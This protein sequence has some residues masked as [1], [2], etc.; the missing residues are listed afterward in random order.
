MYLNFKLMHKSKILLLTILIIIQP[1]E[2]QLIRCLICSYSKDKEG[3]QDICVETET[4]ELPNVPSFSTQREDVPS[5]VRNDSEKFEEFPHAEDDRR[6]TVRKVVHNS[7]E[8]RR[9]VER[10]CKS[11]D[12]KRNCGDRVVEIEK[13]EK[14]GNWWKDGGQTIL[15]FFAKIL[16]KRGGIGARGPTGY[17]LPT[18]KQSGKRVSRGGKGHNGC[19]RDVDRGIR[20][21]RVDNG[22]IANHIYRY[23][24]VYLLFEISRSVR[25]SKQKIPARVGILQF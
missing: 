23:M 18:G 4:I 16:G 12:R 2:T 3:R 17:V 1:I 10:R 8:L 6:E 24:M 19:R 11:I 21:K 13:D 15:Q 9:Q 14:C 25:V 22:Y 7:Q 20:L 5:I